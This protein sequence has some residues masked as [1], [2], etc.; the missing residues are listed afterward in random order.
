MY[1]A[2][3]ASG[4]DA[5]TMSAVLSA[6]AYLSGLTDKNQAVLRLVAAAAVAPDMVAQRGETADAL[7]RVERAT[8]HFMQTI[9]SKLRDWRDE[10]A[11]IIQEA[12]Q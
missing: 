3:R 12:L 9:A 7:A 2:V 11:K 1:L 10:D 4:G 8:D 5:A 6:P